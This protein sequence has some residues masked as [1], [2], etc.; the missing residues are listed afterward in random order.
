MEATPAVVMHIL[1]FE[2]AQGKFLHV[3]FPWNLIETLETRIDTTS[4]TDDYTVKE[5]F[6]NYY[7][8]LSNF[9]RKIFENK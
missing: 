6:H 4:W 7:L 5:H 1:Q 2:K 3:I 8:P 9:K